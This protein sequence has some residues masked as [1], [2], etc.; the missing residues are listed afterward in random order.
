MLNLALRG[1]SVATQMH[2]LHQQL[3]KT[4]SYVAAFVC[5]AAAARACTRLDTLWLFGLM[6][7]AG[8]F[9]LRAARATTAKDAI[10]SSLIAWPL[11]SCVY[12]LWASGAEMSY[13]AHSSYSNL[14]GNM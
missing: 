14:S 3:L 13:M 11:R 8:L 10:V 2:R 5:L 12:A 1:P 4:G 7:S 9:H 6:L